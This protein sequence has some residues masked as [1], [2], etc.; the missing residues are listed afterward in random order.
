VRFRERVRQR[1]GSTE[2]LIFRI[3]PEQF[4]LE[5]RAV[6]EVVETPD[7]RPVPEPPPDLLGVFSHRDHLL[8]LY[9]PANLL[10]PAAGTS[11]VALVMRWGHR[12]LALAVDDAD[13]V[14]QVEMRE[15]RD[16]PQLGRDDEIVAAVLWKAGQLI[17]VL[18]ARALVSA[19]AAL[20]G[21]A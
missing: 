19:C 10:G 3:G 13:D 14:V 21:A 18:D 7:V 8:P 4:G 16:A 5:L 17:T 9:S 2:L 11:C 15:L 6:D 1:L 20:P 12:R